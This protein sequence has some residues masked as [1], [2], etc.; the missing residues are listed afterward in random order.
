MRATQ[1]YRSVYQ[2]RADDFH[3][4]E[5]LPVPHRT[6]LAQQL[7][8][9]LPVIV[10]EFDSAD[11]TRR[12]LLKLQDGEFIE[13]VFI[14]RPE[15][16][17]LCVSSQ[18]GCALACA[19]C[20]TGQL[21]LTRD[22]TCAEIVSQVVLLQRLHLPLEASRH[23]SI[24]FM[25]MGEPLHNY[26]NVLKAMRILHDDHGMSI[27]MTRITLSTA[28][29][30]PEI[31]RLAAEPMFPNLSISLTGTTDAVRDDLMP[32]NRKYAIEELISAVRSLP[33]SRQK[34]VMFE[35]V[36]IKD[37]TDALDD[38]RSLARWLSGM[39]AKVNLIPF[40]PAKDLSFKRPELVRILEFQSL[41]IGEG[42][43]TFVRTN[44]G[45]DVYGACGQ[46]KLADVIK[47]GASNG[48]TPSVEAV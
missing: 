34:R 39:C 11:G 4:I 44:R 24:V 15:R 16:F 31:R 48:F 6:I 10:R 38:A 47:P 28:G 36:M 19:F 18:V 33:P 32:I 17:T 7:S 43:T 46:L 27:P 3:H 25:G 20:L 35:Y 22:L 13:S 30:V 8:L 5:T 14:P 21:G 45:D 26:D 40:N 41:L 2:H 12:Y 29:L 23:F 9:Q 1:A 37:V 42:I